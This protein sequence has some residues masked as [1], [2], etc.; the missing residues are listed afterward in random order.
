M[1]LFI[2]TQNAPMYLAEFLDDFLGSVDASAHKVEG[3]C[4]LSPFFKK[5]VLQGVAERYRY[6][7]TM[8]FCKMAAH[9]AWNK[10]L[11][12]VSRF[13]PSIGC[14]SVDNVLRKYGLS[15]YKTGSI[16]SEAF[17]SH[18]RESG[19]DVIISIASSQIFK[20]EILHAAR[21]GCINYHTAIL[22]R[23]RG[24]Q[25][26]FWALLN[27]E[28]EVGISIHEMD[29]DLDNGPILSQVRI[30]VCPADTL[31][32]IYLK[33][34]AAGPALLMDA[35]ARLDEGSGERLPN[36]AGQK[37]CYRFPTRADARLFKE[38]GRRFF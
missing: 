4:L 23:Y 7:G 18:I 19:I 29:E 24:R 35:V 33:T 34:I 8:D 38:R 20:H 25:P 28:K 22:P 17:V 9:I 6:Y 27:G 14:H 11:S 32:S 2:I 15:N 12:L 1:K 37:T 3:I 36:D 10:L 31:H 5:S 13:V 30:P 16:N 26:L 21:K